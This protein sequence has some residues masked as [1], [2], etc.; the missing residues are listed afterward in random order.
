[1]E[2]YITLF[3]NQRKKYIIKIELNTKRKFGTTDH[4]AKVL[5]LIAIF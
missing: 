2:N 5:F 1:M 4:E 3:P